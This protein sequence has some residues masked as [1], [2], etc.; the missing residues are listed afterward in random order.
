MIDLRQ[1][2]TFRAVALTN[3]FTRAAAELG[4]SQSSVTIH[5]KALE[6]ELGVPLFDRRRFS[7]SVVLTE[8]GRKTLERACKLLALADEIRTAAAN[9]VEVV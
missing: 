6:R 2:E 9:P 4:Y 7:K 3:S 8:V 1:L 5:I